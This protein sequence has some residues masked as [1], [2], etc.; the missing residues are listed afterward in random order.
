[1]LIRPGIELANLTD[2][3]CH[4]DENQDYYCYAEPENDVDFQK[5]GRLLVVAD[6]MGGHQGGKL[7]STI[8]VEAVRNG[9]L[10]QSDGDPSQ[11][12]QTAFLDG[13]VAIQEYARR[14][15]ELEGMGTTCTAVTILNSE[16]YYGHVGDSRL[17]F[18]R[19]DQISRI[20]QDHSQVER[21]VQDGLITPEEA[22]VH[23]QRN[24]LTA[25]MGVEPAAADFSERPIPL[26]PGDI[27]LISTDGLH[28]LVSDQELL[29]TASTQAPAEACKELV[30]LAKERGGFDNITLQILK[31]M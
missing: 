31:I 5:K 14:H 25:A 4:R 1:M 20:T 26:E 9:Y 22:A 30:R 23:P 2:V 24:V 19:G 6:G 8:A 11:A 3:G 7:A 15:P 17:Y 18:I 29:T 16:L 12:L 28:G 10:N 13:H 21:L 27:L